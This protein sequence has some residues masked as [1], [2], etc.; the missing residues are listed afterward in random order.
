MLMLPTKGVI[1]C[2]SLSGGSRKIALARVD[3]SG[4]LEKPQAGSSNFLA[5]S[6][7]RHEFEDIIKEVGFMYPIV[8]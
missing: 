4:K 5:I 6:R 2:L 1:M 3:Q 8:L 7:N